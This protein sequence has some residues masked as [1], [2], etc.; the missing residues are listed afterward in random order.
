MPVT[1]QRAARGSGVRLADLPASVT[2]VRDALGVQHVLLRQGSRALQLAVSGADLRYPVRLLTEIAV[3]KTGASA[4]LEAIGQF[5]RLCHRGRM[6][7]GN[8][9]GGSGSARLAFVLQA[10]D[11]F[12]DRLPQQRIA[13]RLYGVAR[14]RRD[15]RHPGG[16]MRDCVRR[17]IRRG[18]RLMESDYRLLLR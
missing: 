9:A 12:L 17:A 18:C 13:E 3:D 6:D 10:L 7:G 11:G 15:W 14:V 5:N 16:H 4:R 2:I 1:A 8:S